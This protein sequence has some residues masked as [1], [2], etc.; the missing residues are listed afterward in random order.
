MPTQPKDIILVYYLIIVQE[1]VFYFL[2]SYP[3]LEVVHTECLSNN[4]QAGQRIY[5]TLLFR[6]LNS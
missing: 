6:Q 2:Q 5:Q 3:N 4:H 1:S